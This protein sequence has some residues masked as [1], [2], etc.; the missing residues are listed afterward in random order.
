MENRPIPPRSRDLIHILDKEVYSLSYLFPKHTD[1]PVEVG[2][3]I[4]M[5]RVVDELI[6]WLH[7]NEDEDVLLQET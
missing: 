4:G 1:T 5:R 2:M 3:K 6:S 7:Q